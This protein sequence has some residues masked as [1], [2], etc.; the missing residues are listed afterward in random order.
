MR[1]QNVK[2]TACGVSVKQNVKQNALVRLGDAEFH[3]SLVE[4]GDL[5]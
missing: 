1:R 2:Q 5:Q 4:V 3:V